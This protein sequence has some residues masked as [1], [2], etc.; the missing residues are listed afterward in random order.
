MVK[1]VHPGIKYFPRIKCPKNR[2]FYL[3]TVRKVEYDRTRCKYESHEGGVYE[4]LDESA[5]S[6]S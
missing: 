5:G 2:Y 4:T 3:A 6:V 1:K